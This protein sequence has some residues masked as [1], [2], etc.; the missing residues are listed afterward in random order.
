MVR[1]VTGLPLGQQDGLEL[2]YDDGTAEAGRGYAISG[3]GYAVRF[4]PPADGAKL[5][6]A[7]LYIEGFW[8]D[9]TPIEIPLQVTPTSA[10]WLDVDLSNQSLTPT[11]DFFVGYVQVQANAYPWI[12]FDSTSPGDR[13]YSVPGWSHALPTGSNV[14]IRVI[15]GSD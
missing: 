2:A 7:R 12:G 14:M 6:R 4:T 15:M 8:G 10:G 3:A 5:L 9:P 13:S 1:I 11:T